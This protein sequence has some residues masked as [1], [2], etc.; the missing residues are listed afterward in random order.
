MIAQ[1]ELNLL[2]FD[3]LSHGT[4]TNRQ[5]VQY[6]QRLRYDYLTI[7]PIFKIRDSR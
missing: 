4:I 6:L 3:Q 5:I 2:Q 7:A 1:N